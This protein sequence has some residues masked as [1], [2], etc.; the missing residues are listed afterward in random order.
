M[1]ANPRKN[2][3]RPVLILSFTFFVGAVFV[4]VLLRLYLIQIQQGAEFARRSMGNFVQTKRIEHS[5]GIIVDRYGRTLAGNRA[6]FDVVVT[7]AFLPN[8]RRNILRLAQTVEL[9]KEEASEIAIAFWR[10]L[11]DEGPPVLIGRD[12][13]EEQSRR[14]RLRQKLLEIPPEAIAI[15]RSKPDESGEERYGAYL[16]PL[17]FPSVTLVLRRTA[18]IVGLTSDEYTR[19]LRATNRRR[20]LARYRDLAI[21]T[22]VSAGTAAKLTR[23]IEI[24]DLPGISVRESQTRAYTQGDVAAHLLGYV[25]ELSS[26]EFESKKTVGYHLGDVVGRRGIE[27]TFEEQLRGSDGL[28]TLVVDSKGRSQN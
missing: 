21:R 9:P 10:T 24:G 11:Q 1:L 8:T 16:D 19:L 26:E 20:G 4:A 27:R 7:P 23:E 14:L 28:E 5:R 2:L 12:L 15:I 25:N 22:D 13:T 6:S 3:P 18:D 17:H